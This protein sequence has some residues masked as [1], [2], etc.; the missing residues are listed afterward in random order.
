MTYFLLV[1]ISLIIPFSEDIFH[2]WL[3]TQTQKLNID[4][5]KIGMVFFSLYGL[6]SI[7]TSFLEIDGNQRSS[8]LRCNFNL[9]LFLFVILLGN[10]IGLTGIAI[11]VL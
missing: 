8:L 2:L 7:L 10:E 9:F 6:N 5:F 11:A 4:V 1:A 3:N